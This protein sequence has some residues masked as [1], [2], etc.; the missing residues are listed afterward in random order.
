VSTPCVVSV[1]DHAGWA[2]IIC[3]AA[4][5]GTPAVIERRRVTLIDPGL[6]T[7][8]Y[9]HET[10]TM[11]EDEANALIARV[12]QSIA[13]RTSDALTRV[14]NDLAPAHAVAALAIRE[15][16]FPDLPETVVPVRNSYRLQ[17][18][19]DGMMYQLALCHAARQLGLDVREYRRGEEI[20]RAAEQLGV[21][22]EEVEVFVGR[23]GRPAGPPWT[24]EHRRAYA[25]GIAALA[26]HA[27]GPLGIPRSKIARNLSRDSS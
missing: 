20:A 7:L 9:H 1:A 15:P 2:Y 13:A 14:L 10:T 22:P 24:Q 4:S 19:A 26:A 3:V 25:S 18:A 16:P 12:R 5:G 11:K 27:G 17:C 23:T 8:P 21:S 6:P